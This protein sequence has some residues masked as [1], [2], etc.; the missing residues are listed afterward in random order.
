MKKLFLIFLAFIISF[1]SAAQETYTSEHNG[2]ARS[3]ITWG[4][5]T[6]DPLPD[7]PNLKN[8]NLVV[9][10]EVTTSCN[11][12]NNIDR[13]IDVNSNGIFVF[14][15]NLYLTTPSNPHSPPWSDNIIR[16]GGTIHAKEN[17]WLTRPLYIEPKG[18]LQVDGNLIIIYPGKIIAGEG[19]VITVGG[20]MDLSTGLLSAPNEN[21]VLI[22]N[23]NINVTGTVKLHGFAEMLVNGG[24]VTVGNGFDIWGWGDLTIENN[25]IVTVNGD[26]NVGE[27]PGFDFGGDLHV[28]NGNLIIQSLPGGTEGNLTLYRWADGT[29]GNGGQITVLGNKNIGGNSV[30]G[31]LTIEEYLFSIN[32]GQLLVDPGGKVLV[33]HDVIS[34][35]DS[36]KLPW[37]LLPP[38][39]REGAYDFKVTD[40]DANSNIV[41]MGGSTCDNWWG[42]DVTCNEG[43]ATLPIELVSFTAEAGNAGVVLGWETATE[44]NNDFFTIE[45]SYNGLDF[46]AIGT[47]TGGGNTGD[48]ETYTFTDVKALP[49]TIYYRLKQ[50][51]FDGMSETFDPVSVN[52]LPVGDNVTLFPNPIDH[53]LLKMGLTGFSADRTANIRITDLAGRTVI[54]KTINISNAAYTVVEMNVASKLDRGAYIVNINQGAHT[55]TKRLVKM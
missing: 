12:F 45:R 33:Y 53:G 39:N 54:S 30:T 25:G 14:N 52:Y 20:N 5:E 9:K 17:L 19:S 28:N 38:Q 27:R 3:R 7:C 18:T 15:N 36:N 47:V 1:V 13:N 43:D 34:R 40:W 16:D 26:M 2:F 6:T 23:G 44:I 46:E 49:G 41:I 42:R 8:T 50:T 10:H 55:F 11:L 37:R 29:V 32:N 48:T 4:L 22:T 24:T 31:D 51:D 21:E 35:D